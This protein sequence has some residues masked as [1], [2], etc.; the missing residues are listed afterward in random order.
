[1]PFECIHPSAFVARYGLESR[2]SR[3]CLKRWRDQ[4]NF[5]QPLDIP[6]GHY[7]RADVDAWFADRAPKKAA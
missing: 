2:P 5:P 1:M 4:Q 7:R 6:Y 3:A